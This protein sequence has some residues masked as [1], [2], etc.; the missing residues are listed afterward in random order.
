MR[1]VILSQ[2]VKKVHIVGVSGVSTSGI[3]EYLIQKGFSVSGSDLVKRQNV[4]RLI[5]KGLKFFNN[6]AAA[7]VKGADLVIYS[8]AISDNNPEIKYAKNKNIP[9]VKRSVILG[10][11]ALDFA[12]SVAVSGSHGKTTTTAMIAAILTAAKKSPTVF[13]GGEDS[14]SNGYTEGNSDYAVL[15]ACEYKKNM[16]DV[17]T[18]YAVVLNVDNDH[19]DSYGNMN[20]MVKAFNEF[21]D[22]CSI[23]VVNA[24]DKYTNKLY[25]PASVNFGIDSPAAY[26]AKN[27]KKGENGYSFTAYAYSLPLGR[28][29]L[30]VIG[31]HNV[32]N[33]LAAIAV[34]DLLGV[35]FGYIKS[36]L[37][38]FCS[39]KRRAE[40]LG[41]TNGIKCFADY[42]HH[43]KELFAT[44]TAFKENYQNIGVVFQPHTYSRTKLL[45]ADFVET[46]K[47]Y[48]TV[49]Y[50]TY[51]AREDFDFDGSAKKLCDEL[52]DKN[53]NCHYADNQEELNQ[54]LK[55]LSGID[56]ILFLGAGDI[57][58]IALKVIAAKE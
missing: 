24:D 40:Y 19:L 16:L 15:E 9:L 48:Q 58:E 32:Y 12:N 44:L 38:N 7:N 6:H 50:K 11:I 10:E 2:K 27:L 1:N 51:A 13:L 18:K 5:E 23:A 29:N 49:I 43:P 54:K 28:I 37:E 42:A 36:A 46:L 30:K 25:C 17:K 26:T 45:L 39:V 53:A 14:L 35:R 41:K 20:E 55:N 21:V 52:K 31:R 33:A 8:A 22:G 47:D 4:C 34:A 3:A 57:Y 56:I